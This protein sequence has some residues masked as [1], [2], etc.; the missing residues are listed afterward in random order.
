M[1]SMIVTF[2]MLLVLGVGS[3]IRIAQIVQGVVLFLLDQDRDLLDVKK[4]FLMVI[5]PLI[6]LL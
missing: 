1:K 2:L 5:Q 3:Y 4:S 6:S